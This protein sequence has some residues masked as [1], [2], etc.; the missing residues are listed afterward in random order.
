M[1]PPTAWWQRAIADCQT[2]PTAALF[3]RCGRDR[4]RVPGLALFVGH[5]TNMV[6]AGLRLPTSPTPCSMPVFTSA[7]ELHPTQKRYAIHLLRLSETR[8]EQQLHIR[9]RP[10][11]SPRCRPENRRPNTPLAPSTLPE[12]HRFAEWMQCALRPV[13]DGAAADAVPD[14]VCAR[15]RS[16]MVALCHEKHSL[17]PKTRK[18]LALAGPRIN[19]RRSPR[20]MGTGSF[21]WATSPRS[22]GLLRIHLRRH[23]AGSGGDDDFSG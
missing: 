2:C 15:L 18:S 3:S 4:R 14:R 22:R 8:I 10:S 1:E 23:H 5:P 13:I 17:R 11:L 21:V 20:G 16:S 12:K 19:R 7:P 9:W 6:N